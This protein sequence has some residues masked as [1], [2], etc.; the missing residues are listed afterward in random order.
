M[1]PAARQSLDQT[2]ADQ[3]D[4]TGDDCHPASQIE[5]VSHGSLYPMRDMFD[6][7]GR[8]AVVTG[9]V[10]LIGR[11]LVEGLASCGAHVYLADINLEAAEEY[12]ARLRQDGLR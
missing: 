11:G 5:H 3:A 6:L 4:P 7:A 10:G 12:A 1:C 2:S 8:V 9:G